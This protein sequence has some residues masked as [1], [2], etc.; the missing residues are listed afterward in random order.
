MGANVLVLAE[1]D[2]QGVSEGTYE[3]LGVA[4]ELAAALGGAVEVALLGPRTL[5]RAFGS[6]E[7]VV[8]VDHPALAAYLS[9]AYERTLVALLVERAPRLL[10]VSN[11]TVGLD[12]ASALAVRWDAA[13]ATGARA[14][15]V[16]GDEVIATSSIL[17]GTVHTEL[18]LSGER[19]IASVAGGAATAAS[20]AGEAAVI[21]VAPPASLDGLRMTLRGVSEVVAAD[22]DIA[23]APLLVSVGRGIESEENLE[24]V[25]ELADALGAPLSASRPVVDA[26]WLSKS[27]Q[28]GQSGQRVKPK[29]YVAFG[30][31]GAPEHLEGM[32]LAELIIACNTDAGAPIFAVAH[33][34]TTTDLFDLVPAL[35]DR[36]RG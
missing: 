4:H 7:V 25:Q 11:A 27:R 30:I 32:R 13:L 8:N 28:V 2:G 9:E 26:G 33:Y 16:E 10:L 6:A 23:A 35:A 17:G 18:V 3:L 22:V 1:H 36:L 34:G 24:M 5:A 29:A 19:L 12:L 14:L 21:D 20:V 31:S 15:R